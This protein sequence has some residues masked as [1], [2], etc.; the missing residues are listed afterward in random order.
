MDASAETDAEMDEE[1]PHLQ[2]LYSTAPAEQKS[3]EDSR[4]KVF[5]EK[6]W[7][8]VKRAATMRKTLKTDK[9]ADITN[10][11][12]QD[13]HESTH[14]YH[15]LCY[16]KY[17]VVK[18]SKSASA[19]NDIDTPPTKQPKIQTRNSSVLPKDDEIKGECFFCGI[20]RKKRK[21]KEEARRMSV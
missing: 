13:S 6:T 8:S 16:K 15:P 17:T 21:G 11:M 14:H 20:N 7:T 1:V 12:L 5:N 18:R 10:T 3:D 4:L 19:S 2:P 9:Y